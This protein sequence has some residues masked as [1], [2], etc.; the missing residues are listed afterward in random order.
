[1]MDPAKFHEWL[2][3]RYSTR[4]AGDVVSRYRRLH[5]FIST[6]GLRDEVDLAARL[7]RSPEA[8]L[9]SCSVRSQVK[10]AGKLYLEFSQAT[11]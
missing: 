3:Q 2:C 4:V 10:K 9:L 7:A 11:R 8:S 1:M 6:D 5:S